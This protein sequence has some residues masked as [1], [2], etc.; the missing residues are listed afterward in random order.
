MFLALLPLRPLMIC[1]LN[2]LH[3]RKFSKT[4]WLELNSKCFNKPIF[5]V[6]TYTLL[7]MIG[8]SLNYV[9]IG[10]PLLP[11]SK[12]DFPTFTLEDKVVSKHGGND[13]MYPTTATIKP[14]WNVRKGARPYKIP[15]K[16]DDFVLRNR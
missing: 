11:D 8:S 12:Q 1:C 15:K 2:A 3:C 14:E 16:L 4:I 7:S 6:H 5:I 10:K 9:R 13:A